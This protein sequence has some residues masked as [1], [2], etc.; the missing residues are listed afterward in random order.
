MSSRPRLAAWCIAPPGRSLADGVE[1]ALRAWLA[2]HPGRHLL[3]ITLP[4]GLDLTI[5]ADLHERVRGLLD[6]G[7]R[8]QH[9]DT[10]VLRLDPLRVEAAELR[11]LRQ[12]F[13]PEAHLSVTVAASGCIVMA[14][15][16]G[17]ADEV[18]VAMRQRLS[19]IAPARLTGT[20]PGILAMFVEDTDREEW[21]GLRDRL[22]LEGEARQFLAPRPRAVSSR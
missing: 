17:R 7:G 11:S 14:A 13:G 9:D 4:G 19:D 1:P 5:F 8:L 20:R 3:K 18:A 22:E 12:A 15:R 2:A 10:A 16:A 21:R 6:N